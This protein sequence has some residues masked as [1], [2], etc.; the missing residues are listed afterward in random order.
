LNPLTEFA[1]DTEHGE[2]RLNAIGTSALSRLLF[3][4][5]VER[6]DDHLRIIS[7]R[8]ANRHERKKYER[9]S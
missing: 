1:P 3:V 6:R 8:E 4:V 9:R 2:P 5:C 7:A